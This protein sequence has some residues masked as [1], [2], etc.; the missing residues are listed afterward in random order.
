M[1]VRDRADFRERDVD[2]RLDIE[3]RIL[4][5]VAAVFEVEDVHGKRDRQQIARRVGERE[6]IVL[7]DLNAGRLRGERVVRIVRREIRTHERIDSTGRTG[8]DARP[9]VRRYRRARAIDDRRRL[10][11]VLRRRDVRKK[12]AV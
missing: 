1:Q 9:I 3:L 11:H 12:R 7:T 5:E 6:P 10:Q 8:R 4:R 2:A